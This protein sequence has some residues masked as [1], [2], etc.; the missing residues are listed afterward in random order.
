MRRQ[1]V[2]ILGVVAV[3]LLAAG[4]VTHP[5][6]P[7]MTPIQVAQTFGYSEK[8]VDSGRWEVS[9]V[10]PPVDALGYRFDASPTIDGAKTMATDLA[11]L[12]AAQLAQQS[13]WPGFDIVDKHTSSDDE[14]TGPAWGPGP[15]G[16]WGG[17]G[18]GGWGGWGWHRFHGGWGYDVPP[19][20][21]VQ[22]EA[23]L[24][25]LFVRDLK[26]GQFRAADVVQQIGTQYPGALAPA[27]APAQP[28]PPP[29]KPSA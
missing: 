19:E 7:L 25:V 28:A 26:P 21:R 5:A 15:W 10:T 18:W 2:G 23:K 27:P 24:T 14:F 8:P 3:S 13:G 9:Y 6:Y 4:C 17:W 11:T 16:G 1:S 12:R 22:A 29:A 20:R